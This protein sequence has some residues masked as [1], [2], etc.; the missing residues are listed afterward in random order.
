M[1]SNQCKPCSY[2][3][4]K[5]TSESQCTE[6]YDGYYMDAMS[7]CRACDYKCLRC[8]VI[9]N[10]SKCSL[11]DD[12]SYLDTV[13]QSCKLCPVGAKTCVNPTNIIDCQSAYLKSSNS[14][15]CTPCTSNCVTCPSTPSTCT[16]CATGY[17]V[18]SGS[19]RLCNVSNCATCVG[20][21]SSVY[22]SQCSEGYYR[23]NNTLCGSCPLNCR[24]CSSSSICTTCKT[25]YYIQGGGCSPVLTPIANCLVSSNQTTNSINKCTTC[26]PNFYL[27][28]SSLQCIP[29]SLTCSACYGDHF[30][31]CTACNNN[32]KLF[33]QMCLPYPYLDSN[34]MQ[35]FYTPSANGGL[36]SGGTVMCG[37]LMLQGTTISV[38]LSGLAAYK[39]VVNCKIFTDIAGQQFSLTLNSFSTNNSS[40]STLS[41]VQSSS[42][43]AFQ[44]CPSSNSSL[45]SSVSSVTFSTVKLSNTLALASSSSMQV[46]LS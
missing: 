16:V 26:S 33:N 10:L 32:S 45:F 15:F 37:G 25:N 24:V 36:F 40:P 11:C 6:C 46:Y 28:S 22:C 12:G 31:R 7:N 43:S 13:T 4:K 21:G 38:D 14:L 35:L 27:S 19:C 42:S 17:Y 30:G 1:V 39:L 23:V 41:F 8:Q 20:V 18:S 3:C 2:N 34:K 29:C 5:C 9:N 44:L